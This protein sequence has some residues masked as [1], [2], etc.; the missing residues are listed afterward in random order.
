MKKL[1]L[2]F[3]L[4]PIICTANESLEFEFVKTTEAPGFFAVTIFPTQDEL[5]Y[6]K[7]IIFVE[8]FPKEEHDTYEPILQ[9]LTEIGAKVLN[10]LPLETGSKNIVSLGDPISDSK[11]FHLQNKEN[12]LE[13]FEQFSL[14]NLNP[15]SFQNLQAE[16]GGNISAVTQPKN[17]IAGE[18]STTFIGK[19]EKDIRTRMV[20]T[21]DNE[22]ESLQ[23]ETPLDFTDPQFSLSPL[24]KQL[25]SIWEQLHTKK[26]PPL[27]SPFALLPWIL[28][29][30]ALL[31]LVIL[32][33]RYTQ[34]KYRN[35]LRRQEEEDYIHEELPWKTV[36]SRDN[37]TSNNPFEIE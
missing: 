31:I 8:N 33:I 24:A 13:Q 6:N 20:I 3:L 12:V 17:L 34:K 21:A 18:K 9:F 7:D 37:D 4:I 19:F 35:F 36:S 22:Y 11:N 30:L 15:F 29:G 25:P 5:S 16:F 23:F 14:H 2:S 10:T 28:G 1:L 32:F 26:A 27:H